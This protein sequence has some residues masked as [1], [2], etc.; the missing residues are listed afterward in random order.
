MKKRWFPLILAVSILAGCKE[1]E[2]DE[3]YGK[4]T[5][6]LQQ[7][8]YEEAHQHFQ[9]L[10]EKEYRLPEVYR[11]S[12][13]AFL[14]EE[15]YPEAIAAFSRSLNH[16]DGENKTFRKDV[17]YYLAESRMKY[18]EIDKAIEVYS[19]ILKIEKDPQAFFLRGKAY[20]QNGE[21]EKAEKDFQ[22]AVKDC[23]DYNLYI[24]IY[25]MYTECEKETE[26]KKYLEQAMK[27]KPEKG[28]DYY[29][30]GRIY[31]FQKNYEKARESLLT[32]LKMR[33]EDA[34]PVLGHLY[35]QTEDITSAR[36]MYQEYLSKGEN[37]ARAYNGLA[38]C[39]I[40]EEAYDSAM[41]NIQKGLEAKNE[42]E[43]QSLLYNEIVVL[44]NQRQFE[45]AKEKLR[46]YLKE[47]PED[48]DALREKQ[49]LSTR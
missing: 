31:E 33:C 4:G 9:V 12:G 29:Q 2:L 40:Y 26:G 39:D 15:S 47:Y 1:P 24:N 25:K 32:A 34:V 21:I 30:R 44:E 42:E 27:L 41:N 28:E 6:A 17:M 43:T 36:A 45:K 7:Q 20:I 38:I 3:E 37:S 49:F 8:N 22:R 23:T 5:E 18:G 13:I 19:D 48:E 16:M 11:G 10:Q 46:K 35:L 14:K